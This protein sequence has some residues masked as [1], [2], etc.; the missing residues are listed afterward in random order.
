MATSGIVLTH[1]Y[2]RQ[3]L[4]YDPLTGEFTWIEKLCRK[5]LIGDVA[6]HITNGHIRIRINGKRYRAHHLAFLYMTGRFHKDKIIHLDRD[7]LNN[8]WR[9]L[10]EGDA[11]QIA[12]NKG[13][14]QNGLSKYRGVSWVPSRNK[15]RASLTKEYNTF[16]LGFFEDEEE[17]A[18]A[19]NKACINYNGEFASVNEIETGKTK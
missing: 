3:I 18:K 9:N 14:Y 4:N 5:T 8:K 2:L 1:E 12:S 6:G 13:H 16:H 11:Y 19:Y 10:R 7:G 17:A 15:W